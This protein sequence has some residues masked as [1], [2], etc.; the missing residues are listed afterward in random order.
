MGSIGGHLTVREGA[1]GYRG[2][3]LDVE[4][5]DTLHAPE[6]ERELLDWAEGHPRADLQLD[7]QEV[8][9]ISCAGL[10]GLERLQH[11]LEAGGGHLRLSGLSSTLRDVLAAAHLEGRFRVDA[12]AQ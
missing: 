3:L 11:A 10:H 8:R 7:L 5:F 1:T 12:A 2:A 6:V 4:A 9:Y